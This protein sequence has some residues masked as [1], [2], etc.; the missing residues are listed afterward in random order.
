VPG[1]IR[2]LTNLR[3]L[4]LWGNEIA[5]VPEWIGELTALTELTLPY[6]PDE[7]LRAVLRQLPHLEKVTSDDGDVDLS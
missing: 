4:G 3:Q 6:E 2:R 1:W 7:D 5:D